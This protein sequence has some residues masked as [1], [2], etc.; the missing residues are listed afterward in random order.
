MD[1]NTVM[2]NL[3]DEIV[4][5]IKS[6][7]SPYKSDIAEVMRGIH[8]HTD[9]VNRPF[10]GLAIENAEPKQRMMGDNAWEVRVLL[11]CYMDPS[12]LG[13]YD[14]MYQLVEDLR[15][16]LVNDF[17]HKSRTDVVGFRPIEG[18]TTVN[19]NY[20]ELVFTIF[21]QEDIVQ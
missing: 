17:S 1:I 10:I 7:R 15:Y 12:T 19:I 11:Y 6:S 2:D 4:E 13:N 16:F 20:F 9:V 14:D 5:H 8:G 18:G 3:K 21:Y